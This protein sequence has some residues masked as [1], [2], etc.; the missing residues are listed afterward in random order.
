M[1]G[2]DSFSTFQLMLGVLTAVALV[3]FVTVLAV[4]LNN[5]K[6]KR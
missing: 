5:R 3:V 2:D 4:W 6:T 1:T